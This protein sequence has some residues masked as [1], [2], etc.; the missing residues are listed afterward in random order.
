MPRSTCSQL[1]ANLRL[2]FLSFL[3]AC[4]IAFHC[5]TLAALLDYLAAARA[6]RSQDLEIHRISATSA[7]KALRWFHKLAQWEQLTPAMHSPVISAYSSR[8]TAKDRKEALPIPMAIIAA[9]EQRVCDPHAPLSTVL[10]LGAALLAIHA[11]LR[12]GDIQRVGFASLSLSHNGRTARHML[13]HQD[14]LPGPTLCSYPGRHHRPR[15]ALLLAS[16]LVGRAAPRMLALSRERWRSRL[17]LGQH[18]AGPANPFGTRASK[19]LHSNASLALGG[20]LAL[21]GHHSRPEFSRSTAT[22]LT[23]HEEHRPRFCRTAASQQGHP[24]VSGPSQR[25]RRTLQPQ[26][27]LRQSLRAAPPLS[28][29]KSRLAPG[30]QHCARRPSSHT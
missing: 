16:T 4:N 18:C 7:I 6:S 23:Q 20:H 15:H 29:A 27:Y 24:P 21:V 5:V 25:Q 26:R 22:H 2:Q 9:W 30:A 3:E 17:P 13:C 28:S 10:N 19:L 1:F 14:N 12:F 11:S 8:S